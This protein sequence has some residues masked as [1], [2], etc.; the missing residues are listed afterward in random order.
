MAELDSL[1]FEIQ[2]ESLGGTRIKVIGVGG[3][4]SNAVNRMLEV[5]VTGVEFFVMN[6]DAQALRASKC[7]NRIPI[8]DAHHA[9]SR[10]G[11]RPDHRPPG[12]AGGHRPHCAGAGRRRHGLRRRWTRRRHRHWRSARGRR[13]GQGTRSAHRRGGHPSL[14]LRRSAAHAPGRPRPRRTRT[15][16]WTR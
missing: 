16:P 2:D 15:P 1:K 7:T 9:W 5:G 12:R 6:T 14:Q 10:R 13:A 3:G 8:G 4:G 11:L